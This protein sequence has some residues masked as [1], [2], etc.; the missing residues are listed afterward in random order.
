MKKIELTE[1]ELKKHGLKK[2][3]LDDKSGFW[4]ERTLPG[5]MPVN[6]LYDRDDNLLVLRVK[7]LEDYRPFKRETS[8]DFFLKKKATL[9][10]LKKMI[11]YGTYIAAEK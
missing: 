8:W 11:T 3:W 4:W 1:K 7:T 2:K 10:N 9:K 5:K 6:I